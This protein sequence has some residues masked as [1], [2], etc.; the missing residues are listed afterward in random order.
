M[1]TAFEE[2]ISLAIREARSE[3]RGIE[4]RRQRLEAFLASHDTEETPEPDRALNRSLIAKKAWITRRDNA[5]KHE[6]SDVISEAISE[7]AGDPA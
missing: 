3:L 7:D 4:A 1:S 6:S 5:S 2:A